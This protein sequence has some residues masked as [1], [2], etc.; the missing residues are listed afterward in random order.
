[1]TSPQPAP[2]NPEAKPA[3]LLVH[4]AFSDNTIWSEVIREL[5]ALGGVAVAVA[6]PLRGLGADARYVANVA[7]QLDGP[8]LLVGHGYGGAV[9]NNVTDVDNIVGLVFIAGF[10]LIEG[11]TTMGLWEQFPE[12]LLGPALAPTSYPNG[13]GR[14]AVEMYL[15]PE[16]FRAAFC[17][18]LPLDAAN[19]LASLQRPIALAAMED[20]SGPPAWRGLPSWYLVT[21]NDA[22]VHPDAQRFLAERSGAT[23][24]EAASSH[25]APLSEP[26]AVTRLILRAMQTGN[27]EP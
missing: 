7:R 18:D 3:V 26:G 15:S 6:N 25:A 4:G 12:T 16:K 27:A 21:T 8:V 20:Q 14:D 10:A 22:L 5:Q 19:A 17:A 24:V 1:V 23:T 9:I 2:L 13:H 11:E